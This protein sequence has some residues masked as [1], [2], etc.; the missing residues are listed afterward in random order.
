M[1]LRGKLDSDKEQ[2]RLS[3]EKNKNT[4]AAKIEAS[5]KN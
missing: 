3:F 5:S 1:H 4:P 2:N